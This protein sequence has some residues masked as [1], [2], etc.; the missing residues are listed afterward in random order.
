[1]P[2]RRT[3]SN[4]FTVT[5]VEDGVSYVIEWTDI[6]GTTT[7]IPCFSNGYAK[8]KGAVGSDPW[9]RA[10]LY[11]RD[12]SGA[13]SPCAMPVVR[14]RTYLADGTEVISQG[15]WPA[16]ASNTSYYIIETYE[17]DYATHI[18]YV[19]EF[20]DQANNVVATS[21]ICRTLDGEAG[22]AGKDGF[23]PPQYTEEF[24]A[25]SDDVSTADVYTAPN[26]SGS[27]S[28]S[29]PNKGS[30]PYL[31]KKVIR[32][33]LVSGANPPAYQ[34]HTPEYYRLNGENGTRIDPRG[35]VAAVIDY[36]DTT[37]P[38]GAD[39]GEYGVTLNSRNLYKM[40]NGNWVLVKE[41]AVDA[42][43]IEKGNSDLMFWDAGMQ[44]WDW[45]SGT[46]TAGDSYINDEDGHLW[47]YSQEAS[48][49]LDF[50]QFK[51]DPGKTYYTHIAWAVNVTIGNPGTPYPGCTNHPNGSNISGAT[52]T[53]DPNAVQPYMGYR[54]D[55]IAGSDS[56]VWLSYTWQ[57]IKGAKGDRGKDGRFYYYGGLFDKNANEPLFKV[58]DSVTPY[59]NTGTEQAPV[60]HVLLPAVNP[61]NGEASMKYMWDVMTESTGGQKSFDNDPWKVM[62]DDFKYII[63]EAIF[64]K[65]AQFGS[66]IINGDWMLSTCGVIYDR[67]GNGHT[68]DDT[69]NWTDTGVT[70]N[71]LY[72]KDNAYM[73]FDPSHPND[74][75]PS[76]VNYRPN[77]CLNFK[78]GA[79]YE[80]NAHIRGMVEAESGKIGGFVITGDALTNQTPNREGN[81]SVVQVKSN[82]YSA[83]IGAIPLPEEVSDPLWGGRM[84][85]EFVAND[86]D[87]LNVAIR[88]VARIAGGSRGFALHGQGHISTNGMVSG[89]MMQV[90]EI[91]ANTASY[92]SLQHG[93][94]VLLKGVNSTTDAYAYLPTLSDVREFLRTGNEPFA[95]ELTLLFGNSMTILGYN[96][97]ATYT[98]TDY[99]PH[100]RDNNFSDRKQR[101]V[102]YGRVVKYL[103]VWDGTDGHDHYNA[104]LVSYSEK[105]Y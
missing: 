16:T 68:I 6:N 8:M 29:I 54:I 98:G 20:L 44:T 79:I 13:L 40:Q 35:T 61:P 86:V 71:V 12:G 17:S 48:D 85:S 25:Y 75:T 24:Y 101:Y 45:T 3:I 83:T 39:E 46:V 41:C 9:I 53:P 2:A 99:P 88:A 105:G 102:D 11:K 81:G 90:K 30:F 49:W 18:K 19:V 63:T 31:W 62:Y 7:S 4:S 42:N 27:W 91:A 84:S 56:N 93:N 76:A 103:L 21:S 82:T 78:T 33:T 26:I 66:A 69:H 57:Y 5:T 104:W 92:I 52:I 14:M 94:V 65:Y 15:W 70:P 22:A 95:V 23:Y 60:Y 100:L 55:E 64:G 32:Y 80:N 89:W 28:S 87:T 34:G 73:T 47:Q 97:S 36:V 51:G 50:G 1:M 77:Y 96:T 43:L 38:P 59:F 72:T 67:N 74:S 37:R 58:N 10:Q